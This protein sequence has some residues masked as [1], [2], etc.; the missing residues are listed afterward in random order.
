MGEGV[1][2]DY[3]QAAVLFRKAAVQDHAIAQFCLGALHYLGEGVPKDYG[4]ASKWY[5]R[6]AELGDQFAQYHLGVMYLAGEGVPQD[7]VQA[8]MWFNLATAQG[9]EPAEKF[10]ELIVSKMTPTDISR[11]ARL[12]REWKVARGKSGSK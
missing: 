11:A 1:S 2:A 7:H 4:E 6:A 5:R 3:K 9:N 12:A 10:R 8:L